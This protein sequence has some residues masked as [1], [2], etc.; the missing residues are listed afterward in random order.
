MVTA[1][2]LQLNTTAAAENIARVTLAALSARVS[3]I[4]GSSE[5][6]A[7]SWAGTCANLVEAE[8]WT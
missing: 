4:E 8:L 6:R 7:R 1:T 5:V 3:T 2:V